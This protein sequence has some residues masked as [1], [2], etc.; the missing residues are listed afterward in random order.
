[1]TDTSHNQRTPPWWHNSIGVLPKGSVYKLT[2]MLLAT[3]AHF[4]QA[5]CVINFRLCRLFAITV[6]KEEEV[7][8]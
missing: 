2:S 7:V 4:H 3:A 5:L 1:M 6:V 8:K